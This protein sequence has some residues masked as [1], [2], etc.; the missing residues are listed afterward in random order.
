MGR[1]QVLTAAARRFAQGTQWPWA[2]ALVLAL[3]SLVEAA[4][5]SD[6]SDRGVAMLV[7]LGAT[8]PLAFADRRPVE[9]AA[10]IT[11][12]VFAMLADT[13][14]M[15]GAAVVAEVI[16]L[17]LVAS[18]TRRLI[19]AL[20]AIPFVLNAM[21]PI[22]GE[23]T[24]DIG[25]LLMVIA[26]AALAIGDARR[27]R[28]EAITERDASRR[29]V[30]ETMRG[31]AAM[32]E[33]A[34][35]ARELHDVVAHHVSMIAVQAE[36]ARLTTPDLSEEG[37]R[38]FGD[39]AESARDALGETRR[40][41]GVLREDAG[42]GGERHPQRGLDG[43]QELIDDARSTGTPIRLTLRGPVVP[44]SPSV[45]L[46]AF[47]IV[48]EAL[49]N[50]RR[51]APGASVEVDLR[52]GADAL[53]MRIRDDGPGLTPGGSDGNGL[54]GMRQRA[55]MVGGTLRTGPAEGGGF[56]VEAELPIGGA[57]SDGADAQSEVTG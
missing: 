18:R 32:E 13:V 44:L 19:A 47:R 28:G 16:S 12:S 31:Q 15:T 23:D 38:R 9:M 8:V 7:A 39:I 46:F 50:A 20:F 4:L 37:Q 45:D 11:A 10:I 14:P 54:M 35:I 48:Q 27:L 41:L 36:T 51:H 5:Y 1:W 21:F 57:S 25:L 24:S 33:R 22:G 53:E 30:A 6:P 49:T 52:Y 17:Y 55:T 34:R 29:Q 26:V 42:G 2:V 40:L 3:I 56:L 43:L